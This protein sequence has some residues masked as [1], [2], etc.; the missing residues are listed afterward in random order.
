M[1]ET[2]L[3]TKVLSLLSGGLDSILATKLVMEQ[4]LR[5]EAL[6]FHTPFCDCAMPTASC[7]AAETAAKFL[8]AHF[9][10]IELG[11]EF[12]DMVRNPRHGYGKN[13]NPCIDC[14]ILEFKKA[15]VLMKELGA[16]FIIT[17][18]VLNERPM[19]QRRPVMEMIDREADVTGFVL[20][21]LSAKR[22]NETMPE[23][24]G[25]VDR[26]KLLDIDG[27]SRKRQMEL[28]NFYG[29]EEYPTPSGGCLLTYPGF[30]EKV[31][32]LIRYNQLTMGQ[33][34][35]LK[36]GR[37]FRLDNKTKLIIGK[38]EEENQRLL[39]TKGEKII[40][41]KAK[42]FP[43]PIG[44]LLGEGLNGRVELAASILAHYVNKAACAGS[45]D[46]LYWQDGSPH[47]DNRLAVS[48]ISLADI[49]RLRITK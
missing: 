22:F 34:R 7:K 19:S 30:S 47:Q 18:E 33:A 39:L 2:T 9:H 48:K 26:A 38:D 1:Q 42:D 20:R 41:L 10:K 29:I 23:K 37:H 11:D 49:K 44:I 36:M 16:D 46:I 40:F 8:K 13:I 31:R 15:K 5:V 28:A 6:Y 21:P 24:H 35:L 17:G 12:L 3:K 25:L 43:G 27:R 32:D 4:G 14:R 45:L